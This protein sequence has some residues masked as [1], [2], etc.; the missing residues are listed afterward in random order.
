MTPYNIEFLATFLSPTAA[1]EGR[2]I[3]FGPGA[4][5]DEKLLTVPIGLIDPH[6]TVVV[7]VGLN[8]SHPN[9]P[10][11]D[12]DPNI[13]ISDG[14]NENLFEIVDANN[15]PRWPPCR[16]RPGSQDDNRVDAGTL[17]AGTYKLIFDPFN[18]LGICESAQEDGYI[19]TGTFEAQIDVTKPLFLTMNRQNAK[20][21]YYIHYFN[22]EI[23]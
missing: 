17:V 16:P 2:V 4:A 14:D 22:V 18:Q 7:T 21:E 3:Y 6:D 23:Y 10:N 15:Y 1:I 9:Q 12:S 19:N 11:V 13:G 5:I 20:E 8:K